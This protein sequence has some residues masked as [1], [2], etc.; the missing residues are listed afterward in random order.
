MESE[1]GSFGVLTPALKFLDFS[2]LPPPDFLFFFGRGGK[3]GY[4]KP[5]A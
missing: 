5:L 1:V 4:L 2:F 3:N